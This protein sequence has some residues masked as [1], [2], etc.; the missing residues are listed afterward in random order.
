M[1]DTTGLTSLFLVS[2]PAGTAHVPCCSSVIRGGTDSW[3]QALT[4]G[5]LLDD[6][7][8]HSLLE[9]RY[10]LLCASAL[11]VKCRRRKDAVLPRVF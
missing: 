8:L 11:S 9:H 6:R 4:T 2:C 10:C 1:T 7:G 5:Y 3:N